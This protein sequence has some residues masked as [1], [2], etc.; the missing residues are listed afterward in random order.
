MDFV[1]Y[2]G[3]SSRNRREMVRLGCF[4]WNFG[5]VSAGRTTVSE[6]FAEAIAS[7]FESKTRQG[8]HLDFLPSLQQDFCIGLWNTKQQVTAMHPWRGRTS[9]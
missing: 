2:G 8:L 6:C 1:G 3:F 4:R 5:G 9:F 7:F